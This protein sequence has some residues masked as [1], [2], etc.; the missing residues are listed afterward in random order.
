MKKLSYLALAAV[1]LLLGACSS[2]KDVADGMSNANVNGGGYLGISISMPS[3]NQSTRAND[4]LNNGKAD[5]FAVTKAYLYLF[6]GNEEASAKFVKR[7]TLTNAFE[8]DTQGQAEAGDNKPIANPQSGV[9]L[10]GGTGVT[11]TSVSVCKI[12][13]L[14]LLPSE[15]L[16]A[17]VVVN[18]QGGAF[19]NKNTWRL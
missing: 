11:S 2:D 10:D 12:D 7:Y 19:F 3:A 16:Y 15:N 18:P 17:Y 1:G 6:K 8:N 14:D 4:D 5:E 13:K 9:T